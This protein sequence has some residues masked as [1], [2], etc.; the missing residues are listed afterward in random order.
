ML[1]A[2]RPAKVKSYM[3]S[4]TTLKSIQ[5]GSKLLTHWRRSDFLGK[6]F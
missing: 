3:W 6:G 2:R 1:V 4:I 5:I